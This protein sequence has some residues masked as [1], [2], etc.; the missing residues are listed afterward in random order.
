M[1]KLI[2]AIEVLEKQIKKRDG[3]PYLWRLLVRAALSLSILVMVSE[4]F[5]LTFMHL[6][7][8]FFFR[9]GDTN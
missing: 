4:H 9:R 1:M 6:N 2:T 3:V 7:D 8:I 5:N